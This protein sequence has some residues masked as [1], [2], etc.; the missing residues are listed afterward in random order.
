MADRCE[1][2][3]ISV[4]E[5]ATAGGSVHGPPGRADHYAG[6]RQ[7]EKG[8]ERGGGKGG[9]FVPKSRDL[10]E[11][12]NKL[13]SAVTTERAFSH[14]GFYLSR[15]GR[16]ECFQPARLIYCNLDAPMSPRE[17]APPLR[18]LAFPPCSLLSLSLSLSLRG[19]FDPGE[20]PRWSPVQSGPSSI[21]YPRWS[22]ALVPRSRGFCIRSRIPSGGSIRGEH[23]ARG[24]RGPRAN[25]VAVFR[26]IYEHRPLSWAL[27]NY[28]MSTA[29]T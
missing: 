7:R 10:P 13:S 16:V 23:R 5:P 11:R 15:P 21:D 12:P 26:G 25:K 22:T 24:T 2:I 6:R 17:S 4:E 3:I 18:F 29:I 1:A 27:R 19:A 14:P 20:I 8:R 28:G 9:T